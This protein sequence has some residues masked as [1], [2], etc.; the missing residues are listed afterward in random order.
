MYQLHPAES[1]TL[2]MTLTKL[3][4]GYRAYNM[5]SDG[6]PHYKHRLCK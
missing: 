2:Q 6:F 4:D 3:K 1:L 5:K